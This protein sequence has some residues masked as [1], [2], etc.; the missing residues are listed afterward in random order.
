MNRIY[1]TVLIFL[2]LLSGCE[3][4]DLFEQSATIKEHA[5]R[6]SQKPNFKF[7]IKDTTVPYQVF[8]LLR[9][10]AR[11]EYN[12]IWLDLTTQQP[13]GQTTH[14]QY[15]LPLATSE[16]GWL[17]TGMDDIFEHRVA[18]TPINE[19]V[20]FHKAGTYTFTIGHMMRQDPLQQVY[21]IGLRVEKKSR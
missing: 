3:T 20:Y 5:W 7:V 4:V 10:S 13:D 16:K 9:H 19:P 21:N 8:V 17:G 1:S 2:I 14:V 6:S 18:L 15:E 12:N 11:Y